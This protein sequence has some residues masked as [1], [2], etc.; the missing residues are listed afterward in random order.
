[1]SDRFTNKIKDNTNRTL[2][3]FLP[4]NE[5]RY[6]KKAMSLRR[7]YPDHVFELS[8]PDVL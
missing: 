4:E 6:R 3:C 5:Q 1:M 8:H 2:Y 7:L